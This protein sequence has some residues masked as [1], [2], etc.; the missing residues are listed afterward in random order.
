MVVESNP[1]FTCARIFSLLEFISSF[2]LLQ[3]GTTSFLPNIFANFVVV[4]YNC[5]TVWGFLLHNLANVEIC[6]GKNRLK[7]TYVWFLLLNMSFIP[8]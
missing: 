4:S 8:L 5:I 2:Y 3:D 6:I 7:F 1:I